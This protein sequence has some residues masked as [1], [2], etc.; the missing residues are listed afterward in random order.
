MVF[1]G[2]LEWLVGALCVCARSLALRCLVW[3][4]HPTPHTVTVVCCL[5]WGVGLCGFVVV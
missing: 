4:P 5:V 2:E 1:V 3:P